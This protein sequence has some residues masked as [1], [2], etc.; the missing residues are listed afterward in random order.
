VDFVLKVGQVTESVT[1]SGDAPLV[2][3]T[4]ATLGALVDESKMRE[5]PLNGRDYA[6]L[7]LLQPGVVESV[8]TTR[9]LGFT[10]SGLK[11]S[12]SGARPT[13]T[14]FMIDG[15]VLT[16]GFGFA[17]GSAAGTQ[18]GVDALREFQVLTNSFSAEY[19]RAAGGII[20]A[21]SR[22]GSN[23]WHGSAFEFLRNSA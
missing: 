12:I 22:S 9:G 3:V 4:N 2:E 23:D 17:P 18:A 21:V 7:A 19:G 13:Q 5:L 16:N 11:M 6:S 8:D 1:V 14:I 15:M 20:N 10:G